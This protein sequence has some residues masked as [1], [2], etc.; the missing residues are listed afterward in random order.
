MAGAVVVEIPLDTIDL[1]P[2]CRAESLPDDDPALLALSASI[3]GGG[4]VVPIICETPYEIE[5]SLILACLAG[6]RRI[7]AARMAGR[8]TILGIVLK[9]LSDAQRQR[10]HFLENENRSDLSP[11][12]EGRALGALIAAC[13]G[14][15]RAVAALLNEAPCAI[16]RKAKLANLDPAWEP[17]LAGLYGEHW[18]FAHLVAVA[19]YS[20]AVQAAIRERFTS[21]VPRIDDFRAQLKRDFD[22]LLSAAFFD[23]DQPDLLADRPACAACPE[24]TD[25]ESLLWEDEDADPAHVRCLNRVCY[26]RKAEAAIKASLPGLEKKYPGLVIVGSDSQSKQASE[27]LGRPIIEDW[28][29]TVAKKGDP[30][31]VPA[32]HL[33]GPYAGKVRYVSAPPERTAGGRDFQGKPKGFVKTL[34]ERRKALD[35]KRATA[36]LAVLRS[37]LATTFYADLP[38]NGHV[39]ALAASFGCDPYAGSTSYRWEQFNKLAGSDLV[40]VEA[41]TY[42][43]LAVRPHLD[44]S[45][46]VDSARRMAGGER[47]LPDSTWGTLRESAENTGHF[48]GADWTKIVLAAAAKHREPRSWAK[49]NEDGTPRNPEAAP[50]KKTRQAK[51][52]EPADPGTTEPHANCPECDRLVPQT[53]LDACGGLCDSCNSESPE[54]E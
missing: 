47:I 45:L 3:R 38:T 50:A 9:N 37:K 12:L 48:I 24:R 4:N 29:V 46:S 36:A 1:L 10:I 5:G 22:R 7:R 31:A 39:V 15:T 2:G 40:S 25:R 14:D 44:E 20:P 27:A 19:P 13:G 8:E 32:F 6:G 34:A 33:T 23:V 52:A 53:E 51:A 11:V 42:L 16:A 18:T 49:L 43:W 54:D 21:W 35:A 28:S 41:L 26:L 30:G 17:F